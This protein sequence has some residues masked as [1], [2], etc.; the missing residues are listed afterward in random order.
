MQNI[1]ILGSTGKIGKNIYNFFKKDK[2]LNVITIGK[3][4]YKEC[5]KFQKLDIIINCV[6]EHVNHK[7]FLKS[8][9]YYLKKVLKIVKLSNR[10]PFIIHFSSCAIYE[11]TNKEFIY[12][13]T[14]ISRSKSLYSLS[15]Q[16]AEKHILSESKKN[17]FNFLIIRIPQVI[18]NKENSSLKKIKKLLRYKI[19]F[20]IS[21][22]QT[23]FNYILINDI[24]FYLNKLIK[25]KK[26]NNNEVVLISENINYRNLINLILKNYNLKLNKLEIF[27]S[28]II[29]LTILEIIFSLVKIKSIIPLLNKKKYITTAKIK[30]TKINEKIIS[31]LI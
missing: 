1:G 23:I 9:F 12:D 29:S 7:N 6:G 3:D 15:K 2:S 13:N 17:Y 14:K 18:D 16:L 22:L 10:K 26:N 4:V 5:Y 19:I 25:K 8:N 30:T 31:N 21:N 28:K 24:I 11:K 27:F 20:T